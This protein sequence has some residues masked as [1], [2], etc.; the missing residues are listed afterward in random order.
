MECE[1]GGNYPPAFWRGVVVWIRVLFAPL[2]EGDNGFGE[3]LFDEFAGIDVP[4]DPA[5]SFV[6]VLLLLEKPL[7]GFVIDTFLVRV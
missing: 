2:G 6:A 3:V 7:L 4:L 1:R 5:E